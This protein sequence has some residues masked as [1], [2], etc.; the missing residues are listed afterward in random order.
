[1]AWH[2]N[3][4]DWF[5]KKCLREDYPCIATP[6]EGIIPQTC[7]YDHFASSFVFIHV[8]FRRGREAKSM[9]F[10]DAPRTLATS[11]ST[12][13]PKRNTAVP[14]GPASPS[15]MFAGNQG[16]WT[17]DSPGCQEAPSDH[18]RPAAD[19]TQ[20]LTQLAFG[21]YDFGVN[22]AAF[23]VVVPSGWAECKAYFFART[24]FRFVPSDCANGVTP[25][26]PSSSSA[27]SI[28]SAPLRRR[29]SHNVVSVRFR[30]KTYLQPLAIAWSMERVTLP[31]EQAI[32]MASTPI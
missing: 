3:G 26:L 31:V 17:R 32:V 12:L 8:V 21:R 9:G 14:E 22:P 13:A 27:P 24:R 2:T 29:R 1:M 5:F 4:D 18:Q 15:A 19:R 30:S 7:S 11:R 16:P 23:P 6:S 28:T 20:P 10:S 25:G